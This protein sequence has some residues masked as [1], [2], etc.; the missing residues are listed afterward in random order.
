LPRRHHRLRASQFEK[1]K[2]NRAGF[3]GDSIS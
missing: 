1:G 2:L 3:T